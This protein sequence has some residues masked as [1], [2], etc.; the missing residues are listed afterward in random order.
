MLIG[1]KQTVQIIVVKMPREQ[2]KHTHKRIS[3]GISQKITPKTILFVGCFTTE[4]YYENFKIFLSIYELESALFAYTFP[5]HWRLLFHS[6][7]HTQEST[8]GAIAPH[9]LY[10][11]TLILTGLVLVLVMFT[12]SLYSFRHPFSHPVWKSRARLMSGFYFMAL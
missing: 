11:A 2:G 6:T 4:I 3:N 7:F 5:L 10:Q 9:C 12:V 1:T 8:T